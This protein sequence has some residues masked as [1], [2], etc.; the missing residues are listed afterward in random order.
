MSTPMTAGPSAAMRSSRR[1]CSAR[2]QGQRP[3]SF[4]LALS[5]GDDHHLRR[6]RLG[7]ALQQPVVERAQIEQVERPAAADAQRR[8]ARRR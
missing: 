6:G 7:A 8:H 5:I 4:R 3:I 2:D 1:A